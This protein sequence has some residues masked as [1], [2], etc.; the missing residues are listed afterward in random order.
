MIEPVFLTLLLFLPRY[1]LRVV[2]WNTSDVILDETNIAGERMSDIYVRG[3][4][5]GMENKRQKTD[6][7][8]RWGVAQ[9]N[10]NGA[11]NGHR[12]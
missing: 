10:G 11:R 8:Y 1:E 9:R 7:H 12:H 6:V 4:F 2:V 3:F 5:R